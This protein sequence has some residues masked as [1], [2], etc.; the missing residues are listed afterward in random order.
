MKIGKLSIQARR[1]IL[2]KV[3]NY[4]K[5]ASEDQDPDEVGLTLEVLVEY[6]LDPLSAEDYFGTEGWEN[7]FGVD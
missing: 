4:L 7:F 6:F 3:A 5:T 1:E 2:K